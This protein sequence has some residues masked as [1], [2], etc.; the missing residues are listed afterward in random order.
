MRMI[1]FSSRVCAPVHDQH[2]D[3]RPGDEARTEARLSRLP[4]PD[5]PV[6]DLSPPPEAGS[7]A[8]AAPGGST[9]PANVL[10]LLQASSQAPPS[11]A[12]IEQKRQEEMQAEVERVLREAQ[13]GSSN[14]ACVPLLLRRGDTK[15]TRSSLACPARC[16]LPRPQARL[17]L[18]RPRMAHLPT[19][20]SRPLSHRLPLPPLRISPSTRPSSLSCSRSQAGSTDTPRLRSSSSRS[21]SRT[22]PRAAARSAPALRPLPRCST[23]RRTTVR[24]ARR[25]RTTT[26]SAGMPTRRGTSRLPRGPTSRLSNCSKPGLLPRRCSTLLRTRRPPRRLHTPLPRPPP[27]PHPP[28]RPPPQ[29]QRPR[30]PP[31][32]PPPLSHLPLPRLS[33]PTCST[34]RRPRRGPRSSRSCAP[35]TPSSRGGRSR[36]RWMR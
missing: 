32:P 18:R 34:R 33:T 16:L 31:S 19:R 29:P 30:P 20:P 15:L 23:N 7:T 5:S 22:S 36:R 25:A 14:A 6:T 2:E 10:A 24:V 11:Q 21:R 8:S 9:I 26:R 28:S 35:R 13:M 3:P 4:C 17:T 12:A 27:S 1:L